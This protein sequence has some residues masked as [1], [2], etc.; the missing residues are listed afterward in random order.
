MLNDI[1]DDGD[2]NVEDRQKLKGN[3]FLDVLLQ[4]FK[5]FFN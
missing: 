1:S 5:D 2:G 4:F 3:G